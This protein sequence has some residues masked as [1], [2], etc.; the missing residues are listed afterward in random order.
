MGLFD[1]R[2]KMDLNGASGVVMMMSIVTKGK[3]AQM[4]L[5]E[6]DQVHE[7]VV[8]AAYDFGLSITAFGKQIDSTD[9]FIN[10]A[11]NNARE[12]LASDMVS[13]VP[14]LEKYMRKAVT[15][16][17]NES[18]KYGDKIFEEY[19]KAYLDDLY[20]GKEYPKDMLSIATQ[21]ILFYYGNWRKFASGIKIVK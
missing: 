16:I 9:K 11:I 17:M 1:K 18:S 3:I 6:I 5:E 19:A 15:W 20:S 8:R 10:L 13:I 12:T 14:E 4:D 2:E 7:L 21:D